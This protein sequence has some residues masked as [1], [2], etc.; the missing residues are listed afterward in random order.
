[1]IG[2]VYDSA[3]EQE[4]FK[5][6]TERKYVQTRVPETFDVV[7][8]YSDRARLFLIWGLSLISFRM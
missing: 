6:A 2:E 8:L 5:K 3:L 7:E 4:G 1:V